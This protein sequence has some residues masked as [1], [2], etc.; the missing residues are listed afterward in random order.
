LQLA[1][2][3][4]HGRPMPGGRPPLPPPPRTLPPHPPTRP[5]RPLTPPPPPPR[6][7]PSALLRTSPTSL[8]TRRCLETCGCDID[9]SRT[10]T[11]TGFSPGISASRMS[12][13]LASPMALKTSAVVAERAMLAIIFLYTYMS[14]HRLAAAGSS[15]TSPTSPHEPAHA[16][17]GRPRHEHHRQRQVAGGLG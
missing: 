8:S 2:K 16:W 10:I 3:L 9:R 12:R 14:T 11:P 4:D 7:P 17:A 15:S 13:R 1:R 5:R 6:P